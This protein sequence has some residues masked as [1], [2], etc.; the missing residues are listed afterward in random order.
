[1][2]E[3]IILLIIALL[4]IDYFH[5]QYRIKRSLKNITYR[6][7]HSFYDDTDYSKYKPYREVYTYKILIVFLIILLVLNIIPIGKN[8]TGNIKFKIPNNISKSIIYTRNEINQ[9]EIG[10]Y[11]KNYGKQIEKLFTSSIEILNQ[12][13][14]NDYDI[15]KLNEQ[16]NDINSTINKLNSYKPKELENSL[17]NLNIKI[18]NLLK[19][20]YDTALGLKTDHYN[21]QL[22]NS[23]N[24]SSNQLNTAYNEYRI[25]LIRIFNDINM[26]YKILDD[27]TIHFT[28]KDLSSR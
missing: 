19:N 24:Y 16:I 21:S 25:E 5:K 15:N 27:G 4:F 13:N 12:N 8:N 28:F 3:I 20:K 7:S 23:L 14:F 22:I 26:N 17:H 18:V 9:Y 2:I 11:Q 1:M 6:N 10:T